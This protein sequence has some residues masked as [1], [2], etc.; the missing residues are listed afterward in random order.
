MSSLDALPKVVCEFVN[1]VLAGQDQIPMQVRHIFFGASLN[2]L[3]KKGGGL[4]P[5]AVGL[6]LRRLASKFANR[7]ATERMVPFFAPRQLEWEFGVGL[8]Q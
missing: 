1:L 8:R 5:I 3:G 4:W 6:T 7:W 2:A